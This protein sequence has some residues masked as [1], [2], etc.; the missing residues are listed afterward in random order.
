MTSVDTGADAP[1]ES[2]VFETPI[3]VR[4]ARIVGGSLLAIVSVVLIVFL[5]TISQDRAAER[6]EADFIAAQEAAQNVVGREVV[7][8][9]KYGVPAEEVAVVLSDLSRFDT[10]ITS[11]IVVDELTAIE[12]TDNRVVFISGDLRYFYEAENPASM[13]YISAYVDSELR[14]LF[15]SK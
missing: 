2:G 12:I 7:I 11:D 6:L 10:T 13:D 9:E 1:Y 15:D 3:A 14:P 5:F 8:Q 4:I